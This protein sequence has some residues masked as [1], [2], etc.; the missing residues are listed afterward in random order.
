MK[1]YVFQ[2]FI[3]GHYFDEIHKRA[4]FV[5]VDLPGQEEG[6]EEM[7]DGAHFPTMQ[8]TSKVYIYMYTHIY[9]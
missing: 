4:V 3:N 2:K 6:A 5:H 7:E 8:V 1:H 9:I